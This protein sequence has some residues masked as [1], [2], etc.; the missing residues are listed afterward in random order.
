MA[1]EL[2]GGDGAD[3]FVFEKFG[4]LN[5]KATRPAIKD[6]EFSWI[7]NWMQIG[8]G[9]LRTVYDNGPNWFTAGRPILY[10]FNA[11]FSGAVFG[12]GPFVFFNDGTARQ[13]LNSGGGNVSISSTANTF[14]NAAVSTAAPQCVQWEDKYLIII[15]SAS[16]NG[17]F[18]WDGTNLFQAGTLSP[19]VTINDS[20]LKYT[21]APTIT[22]FGG[23]GSGAT[24]SATISNGS[25]D[26][27]T[28]T[29]PGSGY[30]LNDVVQLAFSGGGSDT[31]AT[32][33]A[34]LATTGG[35][36]V[37]S[38]LTHGAGYDNT[39]LIS[40]SGGGGSGAQAVVSQ[41][42][43]GQIIEVTVTNPGSGYTS[44]PTIAAV[45][46]A[47]GSGFT[48][49]VEIRGGQLGAINVLSGGSG[50]TGQPEVD[51]SAPDSDAL[52]L[53]QA[54]ATATISGGA[55][56][57]FVIVN[58]GLGYKTA[59]TVSLIGGNN[60]ASATVTL[61][62]FGISGTTIE[63]YSQAVW[64]ANGT[65]CSFTAPGTTSNFATSA[66]GGSFMSTDNFLRQ[67]IVCL[68]QANGFLYL[69]GDSSI[70]VI[71]NVQTTATGTFSTTSFNNSN[72]D[73]QIGCGW[74]DTVVPFNRA[75]VF[76][77][78][79]GVYALYGGAAQR[80][81]SPLDGLFIQAQPFFTP[82]GTGVSNPSG[83]LATP[84]SIP[85]YML[86][87]QTVDYLGV[88]R[89]LMTV[90][91]GQKWFIGSQTKV[92]T[93]VSYNENFSDLTAWGTDGTH[94]Y[95]MFTTPSAISKV[96][97]TRLR[98]SPNGMI[99]FQAVNTLY[100]TGF[101][102]SGAAGTLAVSIDT[103]K[104]VGAAKNLTIGTGLTLTQTG[105]MGAA[106]Y[107]RLAGM[108]ATTTDS[109]LTLVNLA[110]LYERDYSAA[111]P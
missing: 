3:L 45:N 103:E 65:K 100:A 60:A 62:P 74:R 1:Y 43:N 109:D 56:T 107:G 42:T 2:P 108:T 35:V 19:D 44:A 12:A 7:E 41:L 46:P 15:S 40:F 105:P 21:S 4:S 25:I 79:N 88:T 98:P 76:A 32:A 37:A 101:S 67:Q 102:N 78:P 86:N 27:I 54:T 83:A 104:A 6:E 55:V 77:N 26:I 31:T 24:F 111:A 64:T 16:K 10:Q 90:W 28:V 75:L 89:Y 69:L 106:E 85:V 38:V 82:G 33:S 72:V 20:G 87:F 49:A 80:V 13:I 99:Y 51:I 14:Y 63:T 59:P 96:F 11:S 91:D 30:V 97:Q 5:T 52:P 47:G 84:F 48:G 29:N 39:T 8:D 9:N 23:S 53:V 68:K 17:Y 94:V 92:P 93:F 57:G 110:L 66:G 36:A 34:T 50:Y 95:Q 71:S 73:P 18:I 70:N 81:S 61:M 22:A 58:P